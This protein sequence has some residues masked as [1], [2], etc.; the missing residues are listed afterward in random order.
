M[1]CQLPAKGSGEPGG[2]GGAAGTSGISRTGWVSDF[3][4]CKSG[5]VGSKFGISMFSPLE[6]RNFWVFNPTLIV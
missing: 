3:N 2:G 1:N 6:V 5:S 4:L